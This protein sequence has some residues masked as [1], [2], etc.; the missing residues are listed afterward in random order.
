MRKKIKKGNSFNV[1]LG[2]HYNYNASEE[3]EIR[4]QIYTN[5][6]TNEFTSIITILKNNKFKTKARVKLTVIEG[7]IYIVVSVLYFEE[8][9]SNQIKELV[10]NLNNQTKS[11]NILVDSEKITEESFNLIRT[12]EYHRGSVVLWE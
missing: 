8:V 12:H 1:F 7:N 9:T 2:Q 4:S 11:K 6:N 5:K 10:D 3:E